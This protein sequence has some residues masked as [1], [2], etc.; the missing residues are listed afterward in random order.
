MLMVALLFRH[1]WTWPRVSAT[2]VSRQL[3]MPTMK[4]MVTCPLPSGVAHKDCH[5]LGA[6]SAAT[7]L[8]CPERRGELNQNPWIAAGA[9]A[10]ETGGGEGRGAQAET[11]WN[12]SL[13]GS[14]ISML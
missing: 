9:A 3:Q 4:R 2:K 7:P 12:R 8:L 11:A 13:R 5:F 1:R 14:D 10:G 6:G